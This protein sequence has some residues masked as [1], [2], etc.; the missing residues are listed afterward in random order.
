MSNQIQKGFRINVLVVGGSSTGTGKL[1]G[2]SEKERN[3]E[4]YY[5]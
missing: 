2:M 4:V 5:C 1:F 3:I